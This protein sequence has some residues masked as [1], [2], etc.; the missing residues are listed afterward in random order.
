MPRPRKQE[1]S[2]GLVQW[3]VRTAVFCVFYAGQSVVLNFS[4]FLGL[5]LW[6]LPNDFFKNYIIHTQRCFGILLVSINQFFA[7]S[8]F[9]VTTDKSAKDIIKITRNNSV[10]LELPERIILIA[11]HQGMQFFQFIFLKRNWAVD[12]GPLTKQMTRF[13]RSNDPLWLLIFPEGTIVSEETR[14]TSKKFADKTGLVDHKYVLL[15][16]STGLHFC[17]SA[18]G[19]SID[20]LYDLTIGLEGV[21]REIYP[22]D[23]YTLR[24]I[25]FEGK[26]PR[27]VHVHVRRYKISEIPQDEDKFTIWLRDRWSEKDVMMEEFYKN[28]RFSSYESPRIVPMRLMNGFF[29][30]LQI[31]YFVIPLIPLLYYYS[32]TIFESISRGCFG[33]QE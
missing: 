22:Q 32:H 23:I 7:P 31:W 2:L 27:N 5:L 11:N 9:I 6:P 33:D 25:Y 20:Y 8:N 26:F 15:P 14:V 24:S 18:L 30:L 19:K 13:A 17:K 3:I 29:E 28:G 10:K 4:Q 21:S 12:K 1:D 16:R